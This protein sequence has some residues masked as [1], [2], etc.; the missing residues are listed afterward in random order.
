MLATSL[1]IGRNLNIT[2]LLDIHN[3]AFAHYYR[4]GHWWSLY[5]DCE[6]YKPLPDRYLVENL[7][8][9]A[10]KGMSDGLHD[11]LL[12]HLDFYYGMVHGG[13]LDPHTGQLRPDVVALATFTHPNTI[14][15]YAVARRDHFFYAYAASRIQTESALTKELYDLALDLMSYPDE[16]NSW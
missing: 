4:Y 13:I 3:T 7:K 1:S 2:P 5:G 14:C 9:D 8:R 6:G 16:P 15:G 11:D 10:S 12:D